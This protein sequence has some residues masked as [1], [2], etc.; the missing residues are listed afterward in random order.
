MKGAPPHDHDPF[1]TNPALDPVDG[2]TA[3][4]TYLSREATL[5]PVAAVVSWT[6]VI[7]R[8]RVASDN[9][10]SFCPGPLLHGG[11]KNQTTSNITSRKE[12]VHLVFLVVVRSVLC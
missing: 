10:L 2:T 9:A 6:L 1:P 4:T 7:T 8:G 11:T 12:I 5:F 3:L